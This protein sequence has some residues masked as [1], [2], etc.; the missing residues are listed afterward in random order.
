[1]TKPGAW[2]HIFQSGRIGPF[3]TRNRVKYAAC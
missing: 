3:T 1:M 2:P